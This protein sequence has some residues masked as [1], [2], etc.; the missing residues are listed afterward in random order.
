MSVRASGAKA[1]FFGA[2]NVAAEVATSGI[3]F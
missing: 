3:G 1:H 2:T